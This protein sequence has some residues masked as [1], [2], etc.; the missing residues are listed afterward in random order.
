MRDSVDGVDRVRYRQ[1]FEERNL[2]SVL[3]DLLEA[4]N[5]KDKQSKKFQ[6][7]RPPLLF[8]QF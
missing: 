4:P 6:T 2:Q 3:L 8:T 7:E 1:I 5:D